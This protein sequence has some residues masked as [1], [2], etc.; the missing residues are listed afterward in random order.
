[1]QANRIKKTDATPDVP[2]DLAQLRAM[3]DARD[4]TEFA[5]ML[6]RNFAEFSLDLMLLVEFWSESQRVRVA[7]D[8]SPARTDSAPSGDAQAWP[9]SSTRLTRL[10]L[11]TL[12]EMQAPWPAIDE[13]PFKPV[14][15]SPERHLVIVATDPTPELFHLFVLCQTGSLPGP[16]NQGAVALCEIASLQLLKV[17]RFRCKADD[18]L[19]TRERECATLM[20]LGLSEREIAEKLNVSPDT[21]ATHQQ[22]IRRKCRASSKQNAIAVCIL[23][24]LIDV[25]SLASRRL[26][27][28]RF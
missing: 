16:I 5:R 4:L 11:R 18:V 10:A 15:T 1:M 24:G 7:I 13:R 20:A 12:D 3:Q 19:T 28:L 2:F 26:S 21:V 25:S 6:E 22:N 27:S 8:R 9:S 17:R 14:S 23:D